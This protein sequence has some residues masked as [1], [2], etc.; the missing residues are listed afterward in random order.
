[1]LFRS[2]NVRW[3]HY[4][5]WQEV[6]GLVLPKSITW[7]NYEGRKILE[8]ASTITFESVTVSENPREDDFYVKPENGE[9]VP[10]NI[11]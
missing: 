6:N 10:V 4:A 5:D 1:M 7:H 8:P 3:I 9:Y 2:D 11:Q